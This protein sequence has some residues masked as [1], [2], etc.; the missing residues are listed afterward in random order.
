MSF[1]PEVIADRSGKW[2]GN[3]LRFATQQEAEGYVKDLANRWMLVT[4]TR[5]VESTDPV[6]YQWADAKLV[7]LPEA[8]S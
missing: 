1:A 8:A 3:T 4:Q 2:S 6:N 7:A 5:V